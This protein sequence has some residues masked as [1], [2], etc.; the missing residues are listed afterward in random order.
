MVADTLRQVGAQ[1]WAEGFP[2]TLYG[3]VARAMVQTVQNLCAHDWSASMGSAWITYFMWI[4][5]HLLAGA[6]QA[7]AQ[8]A[9]VQQAAELEAA[10]QRTAA[11]VEAARVKALSRV[12]RGGH[13]LRAHE[14]WHIAVR[15]DVGRGDDRGGAVSAG[16]HTPLPCAGIPT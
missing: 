7:A 4:K 16:A 10:A 1:N 13:T 2:D 5:P 15:E 6:Q 11:E 12:V 3:N 8:H 14:P 9:A